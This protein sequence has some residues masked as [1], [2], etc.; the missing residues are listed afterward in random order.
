[1]AISGLI[2]TLDSD[3]RRAEDAV[4]ALSE[5]PAVEVGERSGLRLPLVLDT[6]SWREDR[7]VYRWIEALDGV[8]HVDVACVWLD[9]ETDPRAQAQEA[10]R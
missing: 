7:T 10:T 6:P 8:L 3:A 9:E 4:A 1:M 5:H 2:A